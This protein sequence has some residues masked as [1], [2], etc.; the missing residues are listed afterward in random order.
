MAFIPIQQLPFAAPAREALSPGLRVVFEGPCAI[1]YR[2]LP[3][4]IV[5]A[6]ILHGARDIAA[7]K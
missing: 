3:D 4:Q 6:R 2:P 7:A 1:Y 5:I